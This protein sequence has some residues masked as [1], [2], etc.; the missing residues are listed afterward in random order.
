MS[1]RAAE[2]RPFDSLT[3]MVVLDAVDDVL[4]AAGQ[5]SDGSLLALNS[6][7]NRVYRVG[8]EGA[9]ALIAKFY[10]P[11]RWRL[12]AVREEH[13]LLAEAVAEELPVAAALEFG[14][15][16]L[17]RFGDYDFA[18][19]P[20]L[21]GRTPELADLDQLQ[22]LGL[23]LARLHEV[24]ARRHFR[25]RPSLDADLLARECAGLH[26]GELLPPELGAGFT[27]AASALTAA[28]PAHLARAGPLVRTHGDVHLGNLLLDAQ[29]HPRLV[30]FDD[31]VN[32]PVWW[33]LWLLMATGPEAAQALLAGYRQFRPLPDPPEGLLSVLRATRLLRYAAWLNRRHDDPAFTGAFPFARERGFWIGHLEAIREALDQAG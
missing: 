9:P 20:M 11:G 12:P 4:A 7:E 15:R 16:T 14:G 26:Q 28:L 5:A 33:D 18:L 22:R 29:G 24:G 31:A 23:I 3:P 19:W 30:D 21:G 25:A 8:I 1:A 32:A 2:R 17:H 10:R 27:A 13:A 6:F